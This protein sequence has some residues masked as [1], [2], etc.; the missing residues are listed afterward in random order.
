M[1]IVSILKIDNALYYYMGI[2]GPHL[3]KLDIH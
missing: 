3:I 2:C 1:F